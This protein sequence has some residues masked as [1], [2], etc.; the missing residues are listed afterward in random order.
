[1]FTG[2][3]MQMFSSFA[4]NPSLLQTPQL[5]DWGAAA[6]YAHTFFLHMIGA[7]PVGEFLPGQSA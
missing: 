2:P 1:M 6:T 7:T 3:A 5:W 4:G